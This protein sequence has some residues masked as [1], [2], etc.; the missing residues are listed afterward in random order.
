MPILQPNLKGHFC[1]YCNKL[2]PTPSA[3]SKHERIHTGEK[4]YSCEIC[5]KF[6]SEKGNLKK[7]RIT[8]LNI[9]TL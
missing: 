3:L 7:H 4:P 1:R 5:G 6:F 8:H 9:N 2:F